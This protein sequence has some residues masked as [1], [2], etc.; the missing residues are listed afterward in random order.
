MNNE[1]IE[2]DEAL[3]DTTKVKRPYDPDALVQ[4]NIMCRAGLKRAV[5]EAGAKKR[6][7]AGKFAAVLLA[8]ALGDSALLMPPPE[9]RAPEQ[10]EGSGMTDRE[11]ELQA[12]ITDLEAELKQERE[13]FEVSENTVLELG[14]KLEKQKE[15]NREW[16]DQHDEDLKKIEGL[17]K[18]NAKLL[19]PLAREE[20]VEVETAAVLEKL[21][22]AVAVAETLNCNGATAFL[23]LLD[24]CELSAQFKEWKEARA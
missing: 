4:F 22:F 17:Q 18:E 24:M 3:E 11:K 16:V 15:I 6:M 20:Q 12:R 7:S 2:R 21:F 8:N 9:K 5:M 1:A 19:V 13:A 10:R 14:K 23:K